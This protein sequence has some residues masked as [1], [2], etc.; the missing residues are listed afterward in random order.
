M[1]FG[2]KEIEAGDLAQWVTDE[3][4]PLKIIDVREMSEIQGGTI[5]GA[6]PMPLA[7]VPLR[8]NEL[9]QH[10]EFVLICRS[11][12]RSAQ[13]CMFMQQQGFKN[14]YNL[15]GGMFAWAGTGQ[16]I[17]TPQLG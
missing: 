9:E 11:G 7:T 10:E 2:I 1:H 17:G 3:A 16:P 15:R 5:P 8:L 13:A 12:A 14:V 4:K 6:I